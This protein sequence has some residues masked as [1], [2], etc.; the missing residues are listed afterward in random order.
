MQWLRRIQVQATDYNGMN[1]GSNNISS[2]SYS[3][4][5]SIKKKEFCKIYNQLQWPRQG[6]HSESDNHSHINTVWAIFPSISMVDHNQSRPTTIIHVR[7]WSEIQTLPRITEHKWEYEDQEIS[8]E[9][10]SMLKLEQLTDPKRSRTLR[11][12]I[13][14][15]II[16]L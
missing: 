5:I 14:F 15:Y 9:K 8:T 1:H 16:S 11:E 13:D 12:W 7:K 3:F 2:Q 6:D 4:T 10:T